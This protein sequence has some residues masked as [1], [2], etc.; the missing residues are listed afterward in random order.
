LRVK[1]SGSKVQSVGSRVEDSRFSVSDLGFR[2]LISGAR[3]N[4]TRNVSLNDDT[5]TCVQTITAVNYK[6]S[7]RTP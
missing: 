2:F 5:K 1:G 6:P 7:T 4:R 3:C